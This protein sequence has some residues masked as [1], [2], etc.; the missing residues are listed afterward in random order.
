[1]ADYAAGLAGMKELC[2]ET[3]DNENVAII[4]QQGLNSARS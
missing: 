3:I 4:A 1:M 2:H